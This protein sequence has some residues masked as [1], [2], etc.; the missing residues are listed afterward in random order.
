MVCVCGFNTTSS[1]HDAIVAANGCGNQTS[2]VT[3]DFKSISWTITNSPAF[4]RILFHEFI[5]LISYILN[6]DNKKMRKDY[7]RCICNQL[8][9]PVGQLMS[10]SVKNSLWV[11][12]TSYAG[13]TWTVCD[14]IVH[15]ELLPLEWL[16]TIT[17]Q[18]CASKLRIQLTYIRHWGNL[19]TR[20]EW[21]TI[22]QK[23]TIKKIKW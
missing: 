8:T 10:W 4:A 20:H 2:C 5:R 14:I 16:D 15:S 7:I 23:K 17:L 12:D 1:L 18:T 19:S 21:R 11:E 3:M 6:S 13:I 9:M 22:K